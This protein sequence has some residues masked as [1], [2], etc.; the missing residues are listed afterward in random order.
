MHI[1]RRMLYYR[2]AQ[3]LKQL[4]ER[5]LAQEEAVQFWLQQLC[6][7]KEVI[8]DGGCYYHSKQ[9]ERARKQTIRNLR[10]QAVTQPSHHYAALL[11][12]SLIHI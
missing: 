7:E 3:T 9:Y 1:I 10:I 11:V 4:Q 2:Q 5:Y 6:W 12:L 8:E